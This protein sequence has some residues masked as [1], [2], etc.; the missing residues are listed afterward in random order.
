MFPKV[1]LILGGAS[2]GKSSYAEALVKSAGRSLVYVATAQ[3]RDDEMRARI[4]RHTDARGDEWRTEEIPMHVAVALGGYFA[5]DAVLFD[6]ATMWLT[7]HFMGKSDL[8]AEQD[9]LINALASCAAPVV[10]VSNEVGLGG[11]PGNKLA[12]RFGQAQGAL[13]IALAAQADLVVQVTA[14]LPMVLKGKLPR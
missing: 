5:G 13:N 1:T 14:G 9:T 7:N 8:K 4:L 10:V 6:C 3:A 2:S 12:R 11:V